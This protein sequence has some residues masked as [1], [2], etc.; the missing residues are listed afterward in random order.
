MTTGE[1]DVD[2]FDT[3]LCSPEERRT[4]SKMYGLIQE[5]EALKNTGISMNVPKRP[6]RAKLTS[7]EDLL[8]QNAKLY[9]DEILGRV[10]CVRNNIERESWAMAR[11][12]R[13]SFVLSEEV[14]RIEGKWTNFSSS[15]QH[16]KTPETKISRKRLSR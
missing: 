2:L 1:K 14:R 8:S 11:L 10:N 4:E 5:F 3:C 16:L 12:V 7:V 15:I 13:I 6:P 9:M